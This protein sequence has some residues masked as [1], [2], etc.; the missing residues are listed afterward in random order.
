LSALAADLVDRG[1]DVIT[2]IGSPS[3]IAAKRATA[4]IPIVFQRG[5]DPVASGLLPV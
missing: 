1:V 3:V 5:V 2:A 4:K